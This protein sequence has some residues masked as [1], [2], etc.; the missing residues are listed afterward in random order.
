MCA[1][2]SDTD[3]CTPPS[4]SFPPTS[5]TCPSWFM[6]TSSVLAGGPHPK[7]AAWYAGKRVD[8]DTM[9]SRSMSMSTLSTW[10]II[11]SHSASGSSAARRTSAATAA[12]AR[13]R[14]LPLS[15]SSRRRSRAMARAWQPEMQVPKKPSPGGGSRRARQSAK[16][17]RVTSSSREVMTSGCLA[18]TK[19]THASATTATKLDSGVKEEWSVM[20]CLRRLICCMEMVKVRRERLGR[21]RIAFMSAACIT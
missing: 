20:R 5:T 1:G 17:K 19:E 16:K 14:L 9:T 8:P 3:A 12:A 2:F 6:V 7:S 4:P 15:S 11:V 21:T 13:A 18:R 10:L